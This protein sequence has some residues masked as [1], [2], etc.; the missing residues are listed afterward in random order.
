MQKEMIPREEV[1]GKSAIRLPPPGLDVRLRKMIVLQTAERRDRTIE[2]GFVL[3]LIGLAHGE[4][5][6]QARQQ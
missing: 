6:P 1:Q 5:R 2:R 3:I 4:I